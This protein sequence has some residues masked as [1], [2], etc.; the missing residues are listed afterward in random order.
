MSPT[1]SSNENAGSGPQVGPVDAS[2]APAPSEAPALSTVPHPDAAPAP[3]L[4]AAADPEIALLRRGATGQAQGA[5][6]QRSAFFGRRSVLKSPKDALQPDV[7]PPPPPRAKKRR[8]RSTLSNLSAFATFLLFVAILGLTALLEG[9]REYS[10]PGPLQS[11]KVVFIPRGTETPKI[12][13]SLQDAGVI[14]NYWWMQ[15]IL[16]LKGDRG[17]LRAGEYEFPKGI[18]MAQVIAKL[19]AGHSI[20]HSFTIPEGWS[21]QQVVDHLNAEPLL[22]NDITALPPEGSLMPD[23]Y[24]FS[25]NEN[26]QNQLAK[27]EAEDKKILAEVWAGR[28]PNPLLK[29]PE[30]LVILASIVEKETGKVDERPRVAAVFLNRLANHIR[31]QSDPTVVY[32]LVG[33]KAALGHRLTKADLETP[34]PYNTYLID[35]LPPGPIGNPGRAALEAVAN[36]DHTH[37]LYFVAD[38]T[39]GHLFADTLKQHNINVKHWR[40]LQK[41]NE[42]TPGANDGTPPAG[43]PAAGQ[44]LDK[45]AAAKPAQHSQSEAVPQFYGQLPVSVS[46]NR[47]QST[48]SEAVANLAARMAA[49]LPLAQRIARTKAEENQES[50][51]P[52][53]SSSASPEDAKA[54]ALAKKWGSDE[55]QA[56]GI[57][58]RGVN[59]TPA[60]QTAE[61]GSDP[62][63]NGLPAAD[64]S[65]FKPV[66]P[67]PADEAALQAISRQARAGQM[68]GPNGKPVP[69]RA[70]AF[71]A[72]EGTRNDPLRETNYDLNSAQTVPKLSIR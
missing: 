36:P 33:G 28:T 3:A 48:I 32:G 71:D 10:A 60:P 52:V 38:G 17:K 12:V 50:I 22:S 13:A 46:E 55:L 70:L 19:V 5:A 42:T 37:E 14:D 35:G 43:E 67:G 56:A 2:A 25:R 24:R 7:P 39:G 26:R 15:T 34:T 9:K 30:Q 62:V 72:S 54:A 59:D 27:M 58:I 21:V 11:D 45:P 64:L 68:A 40:E 6:T 20:L 61:F 18:S 16:F 57:I 69:K 65:D 44:P 49:K 66:K 4:G 1:S 31:L 29:T 53:A 51:T 47:Q 63:D 23:T 8:R 41:Q